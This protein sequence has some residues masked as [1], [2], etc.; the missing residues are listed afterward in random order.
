METCVTINRVQR[1][2]DPSQPSTQGYDD[3]KKY[4]IV[5][6]LNYLA[7]CFFMELAAPHMG[8]S[9]VGKKTKCTNVAK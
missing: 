1:S 3:Y 2:T 7:K 8:A 6:R 9:S 4:L 5:H